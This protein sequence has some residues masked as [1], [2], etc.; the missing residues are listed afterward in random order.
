MSAAT[1]WQRRPAARTGAAGAEDPES[2]LGG[3]EAVG[4]P[5]AYDDGV[6]RAT[7][8]APR[9]VDN[10]GHAGEACRARP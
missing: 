9:L 4:R 6:G 1:K 8:G 3:Q 7:H 10:L 5:G 2:G